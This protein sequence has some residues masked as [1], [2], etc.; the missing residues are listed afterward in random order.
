MHLE[1]VKRVQRRD[2]DDLAGRAADGVYRHGMQEP[3]SN[4]IVRGNLSCAS[5]RLCA[6][7]RPKTRGGEGGGFGGAIM[8]VYGAPLL[9]R[10]EGQSRCPSM[11]CNR[12]T[13]SSYKDERCRCGSRPLL[14]C[15]AHRR[16]SGLTGGDDCRCRRRHVI[17]AKQAVR[18]PPAVISDRGTDSGQTCGPVAAELRSIC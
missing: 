12:S 2:L 6:V 8:L 13:S 7:W 5:G 4:T 15:P 10:P 18:D 9:A 16:A 14:D 3:A 17:V 11:Q 1:G